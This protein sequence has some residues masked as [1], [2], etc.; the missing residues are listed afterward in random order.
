MIIAVVV[1][2]ALTDKE[3]ETDIADNSLVQTSESTAIAALQNDELAELDESGV[4]WVEIAETENSLDEDYVGTDVTEET[5]EDEDNSEI[6]D[7]EEN[8]SSSETNGS[9]EEGKTDEPEESASDMNTKNS[10]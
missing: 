8:T 4:D 9:N 5:I 1:V 7:T 10:N 6:D 3:H 2:L